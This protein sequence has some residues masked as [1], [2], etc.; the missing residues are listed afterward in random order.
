MAKMAQTATLRDLAFGQANSEHG[1]PAKRRISA[2]SPDQPPNAL[3]HAAHGLNRRRSRIGVPEDDP[4]DSPEPMVKRRP[5]LRQ[6]QACTKLHARAFQFNGE[7][8]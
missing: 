6:D 7:Y 8:W 2:E 5:H 4:R 3:G 1:F